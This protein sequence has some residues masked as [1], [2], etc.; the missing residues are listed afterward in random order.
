MGPNVDPLTAGRTAEP[1]PHVRNR[2]FSGIAG[3]QGRHWHRCVVVAVQ[4][5]DGPVIRSARV[6]GPVIDRYS[7]DGAITV[8]APGR[9][10]SNNRSSG[11]EAPTTSA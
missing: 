5:R 9:S 7:T 1:A 2:R 10:V 4:A 6:G 11:I 8:A 3:Q